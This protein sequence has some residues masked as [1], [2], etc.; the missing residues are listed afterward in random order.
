MG[1]M[2]ELAPLGQN[3]LLC[4][5]S[6]VQKVEY[7]TNSISYQTFDSDAIDVLR[8]NQAPTHVRAGGN[9]LARVDVLTPGGYTVSNL[10]KGG[11][12]VRVQHTG[13]SNVTVS[14]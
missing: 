8:L 4:S 13:A 5:S 9:D 6:V 1:A 12:A 2:P 10:P 14:W 3:H 7:A 11:V